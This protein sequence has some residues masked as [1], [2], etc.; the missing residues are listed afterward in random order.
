MDME[1]RRRAQDEFAGETRIMISTDAGGEGLNLQ[2]CHVVINYDIPWNPMRLEQRIGRVDRIGQNQTVRAVNFVLEGSVEHRVQEVLEQ[3]LAVIFEEFGIDKTGDVLDSAYAGKMF[4]G[5]YVE[6]IRDPGR[7]EES[8]DEFL[9]QFRLQATAAR[10]NTS[11]LGQSDMPDPN[12]AQRLMAHPLPYWVE[13]M[14]VSHI[15]AQGGKAVRRTQGWDLTWPYGG[16]DEKVV[17]SKKDGEQSPTARHLTLESPRIR[18]LA[19]RLPHFVPGQPFPIVAIPLDAADIKGVWSL[20][21][22][23]LAAGNHE[24]TRRRRIIPIFLSD[25]RKLLGPTARHVWDRLLDADPLFLGYLSVAES[26]EFFGSLAEAAEH[27]GRPFYESLVQDH[28]GRISKERE[29]AAYAFSV[30]RAIIERIGL[31]EVRNF[32]LK[33]LDQEQAEFL[34]Y[35]DRREKSYPEMVPLILLRVQGSKHG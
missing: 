28:Q 26:E 11:V 9:D 23:G 16:V 29:K 34:E 6:A 14:T 3:K 31:P 12:E 5:L 35:L 15:K 33:R 4:D 7:V 19:M 24:P 27:E 32:R 17:F 25:S 18:G 22:I 21:Q 10:E 1:E 20:W 8:I 30:R 2:F 13:R